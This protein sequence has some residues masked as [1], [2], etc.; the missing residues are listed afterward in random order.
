MGGEE[1]IEEDEDDVSDIDPR[2]LR[3]T[4]ATLFPS[5]YINE[6]VKN[7]NINEKKKKKHKKHK[8]DKKKKKS[9]SKYY[10]SESETEF[11]DDEDLEEYYDDDEEAAEH[12]NLI[13]S[14]IAGGQNKEEISDQNAVNEDHDE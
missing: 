12:F 1:Y 5:N 14:A 9:K 11:E 13:F 3:K 4:I 7:D 10:E 2:E 8:K 6:K